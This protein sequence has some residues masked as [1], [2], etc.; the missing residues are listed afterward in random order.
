MRRLP[1]FFVLDVSESMIGRPIQEVEAGLNALV[2]SL[3]QDPYALE[4]AHLSV[5]VFAGRAK[6]LTPLADI[7]SFQMPKLPIGGGTSLGA[8]LRHLNRELD[9]KLVRNDGTRK[10]DWKPIVFLFTDGVPTDEPDAE[11]REWERTRR[12]STNLVAVSVGNNADL[13]TLRRLTDQLIVLND[14]QP[15]A[16]REFFKWITASVAT[17]SRKVE[18]TGDDGFKI[19]KLDERYARTPPTDGPNRKHLLDDNFVVLR[20]KCGK[21]DAPYLIKY[22][23]HPA[24]DEWPEFLEDSAFARTIKPFRGP[25]YILEGAYPLQSPDEYAELSAPETG[26]IVNS[27]DLDG[28]PDCPCCGNFYGF[29]TCSCRG[30]HC[31]SGEGFD[32]CPW[33]DKLGIYDKD[34]DNNSLSRGLG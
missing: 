22:R 29:A 3:R 27:D 14:T 15:E 5:I 11:L 16:F 2:K 17:S 31:V 19:D 20:A 9:T 26:Y 18:T 25:T 24:A 13:K 34:M 28:S 10:G 4:T 12:D 21:T 33:C 7:V 23:K 6:T 32:R 1:I 30:I 8:A